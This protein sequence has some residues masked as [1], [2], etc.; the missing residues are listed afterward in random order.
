MHREL[1]FVHQHWAVAAVRRPESL[2]DLCDVV[3]GLEVWRPNDDLRRYS[4]HSRYV[5]VDASGQY[6]DKAR[7]V[8][9]G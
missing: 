2:A 5:C 6:K 8:E 9:L 7:D 3:V 1:S 4:R